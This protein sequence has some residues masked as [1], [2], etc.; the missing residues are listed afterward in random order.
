MKE[1]KEGG[2]EIGLDERNPK[3]VK[4]T[5]R[6]MQAQKFTIRGGGSTAPLNACASYCLHFLH[7]FGIYGNTYCYVET[8]LK[9][10]RV[11]K[12]SCWWMG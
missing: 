7:H 9:H 1:K 12:K 3:V 8:L 2:E 10:S 6:S 11:I 4:G 5:K